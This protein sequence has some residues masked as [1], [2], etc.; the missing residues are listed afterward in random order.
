[1]LIYMLAT[2]MTVAML[3]ATVFG[4]HQEADRVRAKAN[5]KRFEGFGVRKPYRHF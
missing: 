5:T 1:M 4:L 3:I 2:A